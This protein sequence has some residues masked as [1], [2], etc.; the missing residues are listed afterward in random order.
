MSFRSLFVFCLFFLC[1]SSLSSQLK[2]PEAFLKS[3]YM[4]EYTLHHDIISYAEHVAMNSKRVKLLEYGR[5]NEGRPL[6]VCILSSP[7]NLTALEEIRLTNLYNIGISETKPSKINEKALVWM[8]FGVHGNE[9]STTESSMTILHQLADENNNTTAR[10]LNNT[11]VVIDPSSNPDG[12]A[13]YTNWMRGYAGKNPHPG[14]YDREHMEPWPGGRPN[15]YLFDLNRDWAWMTQTE[16]QKRLTL[17][18]QWMPH[19]HADFHEMGINNHY[20]FAPAAKP[21]HQYITEFQRQFQTEIGQNHVKYFDKEGWLYFTREVFDLFYPSYGDTYPMY[22]GAIGMT[23]EKA[24]N[25]SSGRAINMD[26]GDVL[27]LRDRITHNVTVGLSTVETASN[28]QNRIINEFKK[29]FKDAVDKPKGKFRTY[30]IKNT[31]K[32]AGLI[33]LLEK[34]GIR[35]GLANTSV[36]ARGFHYF[37]DSITNVLI[38]KNDYVISA[39]QPKSTLLQILMDPEPVLEDSVTYDI[40]AW[41]LPYAYGVETYGVN[42]DLEVANNIEVK[43]KMGQCNGSYAVVLP[44]NSLESAKILAKIYKENLVV[45]MAAKDL[46][47]NEKKIVRGSIVITRGDNPKVSDFCG[48][49]E[50]IYKNWDYLNTGFSNT[51]NDLGG[52]S[53]S[54]LNK[55]K[56]LSIMGSG[57]ATNDIGQIWHYFDEVLNYPI[58]IVYLDALNRVN[59]DDYNTLILPD[60][61]YKLDQSFMDKLGPW[62]S[63]G[64][65]VISIEGANSF[66]LNKEG[67]AL[68]RFATDDEKKAEEK[69]ADE[70]KMKARFEL[71][72]SFERSGLSNYLAGAIVKNKIDPTHPLSFGLGNDY[73]SL[74]TD[75]SGYKLLKDA[76]NPIY[77]PKGYKNYGFI[78][79][80]LKPKL[81]ETVSFAVENKGR[82]SVVYMIDNPLF[83]GFWVN[84]Q[85]LFSNAL[86][87]SF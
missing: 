46:I 74:K 32:A 82:G 79:S 45:R 3:K 43:P 50:K 75:P 81:E 1:I 48:V 10:Y 87:F 73:Y 57:T 52:R 64:G 30:I 35:Y 6:V 24:G 37:K 84:G 80:Q 85:L 55:P 78:G 72:E 63:K 86:F 68:K 39:K 22:N 26:N 14:V 77:I 16:T 13:R 54:L 40:S 25:S 29:Y 76:Y 65:K 47:I 58:S 49:V 23:Y 69:A 8:S 66:F 71:Y 18:N 12:N 9:A 53:F 67:Y 21:L 2:S 5:T 34:H 51:G 20:Y 7:E 17:Y 41:A 15:H 28:N 38:E 4:E 27:T 70:R 42:Q 44:W 19:I 62:I 56:V 60:G 83:R 31:P 33:N 61:R 59:L 36:N 11:V